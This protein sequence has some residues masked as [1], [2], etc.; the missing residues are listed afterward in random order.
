MPPMLLPSQPSLVLHPFPPSY[1]Y[2]QAPLPTASPPQARLHLRYKEPSVPPP[3]SSPSPMPAPASAAGILV[4]TWCTLLALQLSVKFFPLTLP[5]LPATATCCCSQMLSMYECNDNN[6]YL[7]VAC[8]YWRAPGHA[9]CLSGGTTAQP[10]RNR[11][12]A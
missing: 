10:T 7:E 8:Q 6:E 3:H 2:H 1:L 12:L 11:Q 9:G 5:A 4:H